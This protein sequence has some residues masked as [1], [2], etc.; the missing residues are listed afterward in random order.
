VILGSGTPIA[1]PERQG[2]S[3][4]IIVD[5]VSYIVDAGAGVVRRAA[6]DGLPTGGHR[7]CYAE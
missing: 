4:A 1:D 2:P 7:Q 6:A 3:V 5:G